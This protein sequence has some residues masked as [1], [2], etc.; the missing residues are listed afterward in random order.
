MLGNLQHDGNVSKA[1]RTLNSIK[2]RWLLALIPF[3]TF[4]SLPLKHAFCTAKKGICLHTRTDGKLKQTL[5]L[6]SKEKS[7]KKY[8]DKRHAV[9]AVHSSSHL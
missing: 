9:C 5:L 1:F 4:F 3:G 8:Y 7:K 6:G 2:Q